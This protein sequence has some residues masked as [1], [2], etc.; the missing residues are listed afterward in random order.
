MSWLKQTLWMCVIAAAV[1]PTIWAGEEKKAEKAASAPASADD[2]AKWIKQ[3]DADQFADRQAATES[4]FG[5]G[6]AA[7]PAL[8]EAAT[9]NSLEVTVRSIDVLQRLMESSDNALKQA[10]KE[11]LEKIAKSD[12][13]SASRRAKQVLQPQDEQQAPQPMGGMNIGR[14]QIQIGG[15]NMKRVSTSETNGVKKIEAEEGD[16]KVEITKNADDS[17]KMVITEKVDGKKTTKKYEAKNPAELKKKAPKAYE[18]YKEY[19]EDNN[20]MGGVL[21]LQ[22]GGIQLGGLPAMP[23]M[24]ALPIQPGQLQ[25]IQIG[26]FGNLNGGEPIGGTLKA[27]SESLK[28]MRDALAPEKLLPDEKKEMKAR[29]DELKKQL[30]ELDQRLQEAPKEK[31]AKEDAKEEAEAEEK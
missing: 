21:Q 14:V 20:P 1:S 11:G 15:A 24:P 5:A 19:A 22:G 23:A 27:W 17:I 13:S 8:T 12:K 18:T 9:S 7:I 31:D 4:L 16:R 30:D 25:G 10:A 6:K 2:I 3:L 29:I 28:T 26:P